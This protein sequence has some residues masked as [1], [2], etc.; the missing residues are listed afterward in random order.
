MSDNSLQFVS[1]HTIRTLGLSNMHLKENRTIKEVI[2]AEGA[3]VAEFFDSALK[4]WRIHEPN[5]ITI[6]EQAISDDHID[7][8][9]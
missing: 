9:C 1:E 8:L 6:E 3:N 7:R 5:I 4:C 2:F